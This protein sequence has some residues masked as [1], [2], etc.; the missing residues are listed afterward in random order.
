MEHATA[1]AKR[2]SHVHTTA[3]L[4]PE[5]ALYPTHLERL[6]SDIAEVSRG[7]L[8]GA[9]NL[10]DRSPRP[11]PCEKK[12]ARRELEATS[13]AI[14]ENP[15]RRAK[16]KIAH[17]ARL[18]GRVYSVSPCRANESIILARDVWVFSP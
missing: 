2:Y 12:Q 16:E 8:A 14:E 6:S 7:V 15:T 4:T 5:H 17:F 13:N 10:V 1:R 18:R 3:P 11:S 9:E